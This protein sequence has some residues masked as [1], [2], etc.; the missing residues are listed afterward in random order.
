M[1]TF[2]L[3][4]V[5]LITAISLIV[6]KEKDGVRT[7]FAALCLA[8]FVLKAGEFLYGI[9]QAGF[10]KIVSHLGLLAALPLLMRFERIFLRGR[11]FLSLRDV[12]LTAVIGLFFVVSF[13]T[14]LHASRNFSL[15]LNL[16]SAAVL[17]YGYLALLVHI[18]RRPAGV[19]KKRMI[20]T[21]IACAATAFVSVSDALHYLILGFPPFSNLAG[22]ALLYF[23]F[24]I[25]VHPRLPEFYEIMGRALVIVV[26]S[27]FATLTFYVIVGLF[28]TVSQLYVTHVLM[29]SLL[30]VLSIDPVKLILKKVFNFYFPE[31]KDFFTSLYAFDQEVEKEKSAMLEEM[32]T[33]L[34]HEIRNPLGSI[35][36]AGQYLKSETANPEDQK[37]LDVIIEETDRLNGVVSKFMNYAKPYAVHPRLQDI[38]PIVEKAVSIV[39]AHDQAANVRVETDLHPSLTPVHVDGEQMIQVILNIAFNGIE[40]MPEGGTLAIRTSKIESEEGDAVAVSIRDSGKGIGREEMKNIFKPFFTTKKRGVGLGLAICR[41]IIRNHGG[42]IRAKSI[43]GQGTVF[44]IRIPVPEETK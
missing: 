28:G 1:E 31:A 8:V 2:T 38:N 3:A 24:V 21:A 42:Q 23:M 18:R 26:V 10:W 27:L 34:A 4:A 32:A 6:S 39:R 29:A 17:L 44:F 33:A 14:P 40:A 41:R 5:S 22:A 15:A 30:I 36:G 11:T 16:Y 13:F 9:F 20:F 19:E 43:P 35:K 37:L 25:I 7:S 12:V